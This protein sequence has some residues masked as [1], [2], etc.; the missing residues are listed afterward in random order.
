MPTPPFNSS[1]YGDRTGRMIELENGYL[2]YRYGPAGTCEIVN[3][4][5]AVSYRGKG[6][7]TRLLAKLLDEL[8]RVKSAK[9]IYAFTT[10]DNRG[11]HDWYRKNGFDLTL[12]PGFYPDQAAYICVK[13]LVQE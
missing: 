4:E 7:G 6:I 13:R 5:V 11:A 8:E 10:I 12:V 2:E 9:V 1:A 3:I